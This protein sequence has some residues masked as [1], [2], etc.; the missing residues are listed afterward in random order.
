MQENTWLSIEELQN[1]QDSIQE[2]ESTASQSNSLTTQSAQD[3]FSVNSNPKVSI[4]EQNNSTV[5][6]PSTQESDQRTII[7]KSDRIRYEPIP[8]WVKLSINEVQQQENK[9]N[10]MIAREQ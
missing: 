9:L 1:A 5:S 7:R 4:T 8:H 2:Y 10:Q 6:L 3:S